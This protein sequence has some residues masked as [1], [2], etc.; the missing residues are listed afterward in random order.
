MALLLEE[1]G[2]PDVAEYLRHDDRLILVVGSTEQHGRHMAFASDVW[3]PWEIARRLSD[4]TGVLLAPPVNYGMSLH[5]LGFPGSLSLRPHTLTSIII[6]LLE[7][8]YEHGFRRILLL[9]GHGGNIPSIQSAL[10]EALHEL[11]GLQV[12]LGMWWHEPEVKAVF[13]QA[14]PGKAGGHADAGETSLVLAIRPDAVHLERAAYSPDSPS[15]GFLTRQLF[16]DSFPHGVIGGD[17]RQA[18]AKVGEQALAA[19]VQ[20][21]EKVLHDWKPTG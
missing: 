19:A 4:R 14:F 13:D 11:H 21:Y 12:W 10:A 6:D 18:S 7:S 5:H 16:L 15:P 20:V 17:P 1:L 9:N 2:W 8:A 3:Q